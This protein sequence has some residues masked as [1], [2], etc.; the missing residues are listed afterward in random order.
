MQARTGFATCRC[1]VE[2]VIVALS[3]QWC[4]G[5]QLEIEVGLWCPSAALVMPCLAM[6]VPAIAAIMP[7]VTVSVVWRFITGTTAKE[8]L[9]NESI[10]LRVK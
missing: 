8:P 1:I 4:I 6:T 5:K 3:A 7:A 10:R 2:L 9:N